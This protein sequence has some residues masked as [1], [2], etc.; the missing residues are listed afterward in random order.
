V[1]H[2]FW[3]KIQAK[4]GKVLRWWA[5]CK[6]ISHDNFR[7]EKNQSKIGLVLQIKCISY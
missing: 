2:S 6:K 4:K 7:V 1:V 5:G 3:R